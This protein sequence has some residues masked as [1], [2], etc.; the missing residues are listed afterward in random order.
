MNALNI[1]VKDKNNTAIVYF[2]GGTAKDERWVGT[3]VAVHLPTHQHFFSFNL[4]DT[5]CLYALSTCE[6]IVVGDSTFSWWTAYLA[7]HS[8]VVAPVKDQPNFVQQDY[9]PPHWMV[10]GPNTSQHKLTFPSLTSTV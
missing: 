7:G 9:Y 4:P 3:N 2:V 6:N 10:I 1:F 8:S 5:V